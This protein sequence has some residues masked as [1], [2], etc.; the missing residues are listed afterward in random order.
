[1]SLPT[2][3]ERIIDRKQEEVDL[4]RRLKP[5]GDLER[6][7]RQRQD[8][9]GFAHALS[10]QVLAGQPAVIA[11]IKKASPSKGVIR[12]PFEPDAIA[13]AYA[14]S[15]AAALSVLTDRDFFQGHADYLTQAR[16][17]CQLPVLRKDFIID[18][19][20]VAETAAMGADCMLL[21]VAALDDAKL[22]DLFAY[23]RSLGLDV[24]VEVHN[25]GEM[26][27]ALRL[28]ED[29]LIG[30]NNRNLHSFEVNLQHT[31]DL[32]PMLPADRFLVTESGIL[33]R[34]DVG[35]MRAHQI[36][37]FLVGEAFMREPD[38]GQALR[39]LFF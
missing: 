16:L 13:R 37:A 24:L 10:S 30:V 18:P 12:D 35:N 23:G 36:H 20:Q 6:K 27:R 26:E 31:L 29:A 21:I 14:R 39:A 9:R 17:A 3:L 5:I 34:E 19:W 32:L 7:A 38:P 22:G 25:A 28:G 11:E 15:G 8:V 4:G 2:I 1:M 33:T